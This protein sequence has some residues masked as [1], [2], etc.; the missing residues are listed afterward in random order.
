MRISLHERNVLVDAVC[1]RDEA[2]K[3][4]LFGSRS[5]DTKKGGDIDIAIL[6]QKIAR[7]DKMRIRRDIKDALGE[8][9]VDIVI[10][11]DG[12]SPF[13]CMAVQKGVCLN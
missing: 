2:A 12:G 10:S 7:I 5:D 13:F 3:V 1:K 4:W 11:A 6:S 8:Q 9:K